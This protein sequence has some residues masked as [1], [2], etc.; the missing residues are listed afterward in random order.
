MLKEHVLP[1]YANVEMLAIEN[2]PATRAMYSRYG[3]RSVKITPG[4]EWQQ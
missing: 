1:K 3:I 2:N 4:E